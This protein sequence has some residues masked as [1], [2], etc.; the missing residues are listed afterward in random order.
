MHHPL[1]F[2]LKCRAWCALA[3]T[4]ALP[5]FL[6]GCGFKSE[7][8]TGLAEQIRH[9]HPSPVDLTIQSVECSQ[10]QAQTPS[11][12]VVTFDDAFELPA[13]TVQ[14]PSATARFPSSFKFAHHAQSATWLPSGYFVEV[15][16][17]FDGSTL[18]A[19]DAARTMVQTTT[20]AVE[21]GIRA[22]NGAYARRRLKLE[23][24]DSY[25]G[26]ASR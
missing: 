21:L 19:S 1:S 14:V 4:A 5:F 16:T 8:E 20:T 10:S 3:L 9:M 15:S 6:A 25:A 18:S 2:P 13:Q 7:V 17:S 23:N 12:C 24:L 26:A 11:T 22:T